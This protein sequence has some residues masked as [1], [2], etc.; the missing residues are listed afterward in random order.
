M[1][2][3][4]PVKVV[5]VKTDDTVSFKVF[6]YILDKPV[7]WITTSFVTKTGY[8]VCD[9]TEQV[10][11]QDST[12]HVYEAKC[13]DGFAYADVFV[14][15]STFSPE[16]ASADTTALPDACKNPFDGQVVRY[17]FVFSCNCEETPEIPDEIV[18]GIDESYMQCAGSTAI[19]S[20]DPHI[21]TYDVKLFGKQTN[22]NCA[23]VLMNFDSHLFDR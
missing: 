10:D 9:K 8:E 18:G 2:Y 19:V 22:T 5:E 17:T 14:H 13:H 20:G 16:Q 12:E 6:N 11:F 7:D 23:I 3:D 21:R 15:S 4:T 1:Y